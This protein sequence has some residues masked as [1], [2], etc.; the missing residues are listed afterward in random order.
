MFGKRGPWREGPY[1]DRHFETLPSCAYV[2]VALLDEL[3]VEVAVA[4]ALLDDATERVV[5]NAIL[6]ADPGRAHLAVR[7]ERGVCGAPRGMTN[8]AIRNLSAFFVF[9]FAALAA[10]QIY[11]QTVAAPDIAARPTNPRH[12]ILD[13][14]RG[15]ILATD[16]TVLAQTIGGK[17][18]YPL[19]AAAGATGRVRIDPLRDERHRAELRPGSVVAR[20][21]R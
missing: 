4:G 1:E 6:G 19:G 16:G 12:A 8:R 9:M 14:G 15:R 21:Q 2:V 18:V 17:R 10:R 11:V 20:P 3:G 5:V 7:T 13:A